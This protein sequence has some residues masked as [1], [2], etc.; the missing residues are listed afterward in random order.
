MRERDTIQKFVDWEIKATL[1]KEHGLIGVILPTNHERVVPIR[2]RD[3]IQSGYASWIDWHAIES[4]R[5]A[6]VQQLL[7]SQQRPRT[8]INNSRELR[9]R[10]G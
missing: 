2:L 3:N 1:D 5:N 9:Q 8:L 7:Q 4:N 6:F 10:N